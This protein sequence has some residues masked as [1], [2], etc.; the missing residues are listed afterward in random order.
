MSIDSKDRTFLRLNYLKQLVHYRFICSIM[1]F[2]VVVVAFNGCR[3]PVCPEPENH[4]EE[5][6]NTCEVVTSWQTKNSG[7][8][9]WLG[10]IEF[11][12]ALTGYI[13]GS[14]GVLIKTEDGGTSFQTLNLGTTEDVN[15]MDFVSH[16]TGFVATNITALS[17]GV[18]HLYKTTNGG[19]SF[20]S[21]NIG[22]QMY[23]RAIKFV[24]D[25][26]CFAAG[27]EFPYSGMFIGK[28]IKT[29]DQGNTWTTINV[30]GLRTVYDIY[31][32]S[33]DTGFL[34]GSWGQ[35]YRTTD[36]GVN[37]TPVTI[38]LTTT[39]D[40]EDILYSGITFINSTVGFCV[41]GSRSFDDNFILKTIDGGV[42]WSRIPNPSSTYN[43]YMSVD[44]SS[45]KVGYISG[46]NPGQN[47]SCILKTSDG[48]DTWSTSYL[49]SPRLS[50]MQV[51]DCNTIYITGNN[52]TLLKSN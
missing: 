39:T 18:S 29:V 16:S 50:R 13:A 14:N 36:G 1:F 37:W 48:G 27:G 10:H 23:Y 45:D 5:Q 41:G 22:A 46:G 24:N 40:T 4:S 21:I 49:P 30:P 38:N 11:I 51:V 20:T 31:F 12:N 2:S 7:V 15:A 33:T 9:V 35:I 28:L 26:V 6:N 43:F 17:S 19:Q 44:F 32:S 34:C 52:G 47:A 3:M 42:T 25:S 8:S